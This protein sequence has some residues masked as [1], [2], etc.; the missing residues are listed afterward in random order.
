MG[1]KFGSGKLWAGFC[2]VAKWCVSAM[3][4]F[5]LISP[6]LWWT[7]I[8]YFISPPDFSGFLE[9][10]PIAVTDILSRERIPIHT[11]YGVDDFKKKVPVFRRIIS[12]DDI[13]HASEHS[14]LRFAITSIEDNRFWEHSGVDVIAFLGRATWKNTLATVKTTWHR[15][16]LTI[17]YNEGASTLTQQVC[18]LI[19]FPDDLLREQKGFSSKLKKLE[20][21]FKEQSCA[22]HLESY[23]AKKL[24]S[25]EKAKQAVFTMFANIVPMGN[26]RYGFSAAAGFY[27]AKT[28]DELNIDDAAMLAGLPK[29][30]QV[31]SHAGVAGHRRNVVLGLMQ[32]QGYLTENELMELRGV[33]STQKTRGNEEQFASGVA[34]LVRREVISKVGE[35]EFFSGRITIETTVSQRAQEILNR[36]MEFA[37]EEYMKRHRA[38][39]DTELAKL[40]DKDRE[41]Y[42][43][44]E[45]HMSSEELASF[46]GAAIVM[47]NNGEI[48]AIYPG[49]GARD[50]SLNRAYPSQKNIR[51]QPGSFF[52]PFVYLTAFEKGYR[53]DCDKPGKGPCKILDRPVS[54]KMGKKKPR[55]TIH[56]YDFEF[57]GWITPRQAIAESRNGATVWLQYR[58]TAKEIVERAY[59]LGLPLSVKAYPT[60]AIGAEEV[61]PYEMARAFAAFAN[62]GKLVKPFLIKRVSTLSGET[63]LAHTPYSEE[64]IDPDIALTMAEALR[65]TILMPHATGQS[66]RNFPIQLM[67]KTGTTNKFRDAWFGASTYGEDGI[68]IVVWFGFDD[69]KSLSRDSDQCFPKNPLKAKL[70]C[71]PGGRVALPAARMFLEQYYAGSSAPSLPEAVELSARKAAGLIKQVPAKVPEEDSEEE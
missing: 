31:Y 50:T 39:V 47:K 37:A 42:L 49:R 61:T 21:K 26:G 5:I 64:V 45:P 43:R 55:K 48:L 52:K 71:E 15:K 54:V 20:R 27:F 63:I 41:A 1:W 11:F 34:D 10:R 59:R 38:F 69:N 60:T 57:K 9:Y 62:G 53:L 51:R 56:N 22:V 17:I 3:L 29:N 46:Q 24:G 35:P 2:R 14:K 28:I 65:S 70:N 4:I 68:T 13:V 36:S 23:L 18:R 58:L 6:I 16:K 44:A 30:P 32:R 66:L 33:K 40:S 7:A 25:Y 12:F 19:Y 8:H 67:A